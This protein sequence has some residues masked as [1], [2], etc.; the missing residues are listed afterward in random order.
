[1]LIVVQCKWLFKLSYFWLILV[2]LPWCNYLCN[3]CLVA[4]TWEIML[5]WKSN[6]FYL[7]L[8]LFFIHVVSSFVGHWQKLLKRHFYFIFSNKKKKR[9]KKYRI[10]K[11]ISKHQNMFFINFCVALIYFPFI[12]IVMRWTFLLIVI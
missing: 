10:L 12:L 7:D 2:L 3:I 5:E 4:L 9:K 11:W 1:M 6:T 8:R